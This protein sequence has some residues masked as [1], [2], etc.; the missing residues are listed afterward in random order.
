MLMHKNNH[1]FSLLEVLI[2]LA[3]SVV[4][5]FAATIMLSQSMTVGTR[6]RNANTLNSE[7]NYVMFEMDAQVQK[8]GYWSN[9]SSSSTNPFQT[10]GN[11]ISVNASSNCVLFTYDYNNDGTVA[12]ITSGVSDDEHYGYRLDGHSIQYR[13][14]GA[15]FSCA[16][17][18]NTWVNMTDP[19]RVNV[20]QFTTTL[21]STV[22][23]LGGSSTITYRTLTVTIVAN[24]ISDPTVTQTITRTITISNGKY[25]P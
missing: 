21:N 8:A 15:P 22:I 12:A 13:P 3:L 20:T 18:S 25:A 5:I 19:G 1:G 17:A 11:D 9:S 10:G 24:L 7:L 2:G 23:N 4:I 14:P 6:T 16:A